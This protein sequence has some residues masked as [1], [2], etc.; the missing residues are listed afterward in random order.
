M[1]PGEGTPGG[2]TGKESAH[3]HQPSIALCQID[4]KALHSRLYDICPVQSQRHSCGCYHCCTDLFRR[5]ARHGGNNGSM[6]K[7]KIH[8]LKCSFVGIILHFV[9]PA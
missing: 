3:H 4:G 7:T 9:T 8:M 5:L 1:Q 6:I 2:H